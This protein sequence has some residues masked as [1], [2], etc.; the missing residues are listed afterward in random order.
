MRGVQYLTNGFKGRTFGIPDSED[1]DP[2]GVKALE[3][4]GLN[5]R[6]AGTHSRPSAEMFEFRPSPTS[7]IYP[8]FAR[9]S[10]DSPLRG[11]TNSWRD[12]THSLASVDRG[13]QTDEDESKS[14]SNSPTKEGDSR[15]V[16][17]AKE[18]TEHVEEDDVDDHSPNSGP[19][20]DVG[21]S[22]QVG[23]AIPVIARARVVNVPKRVPPRPPALPPRNPDRVAPVAEGADEDGFD[24][25]P[26]DEPERSAGG[27]PVDGVVGNLE[28]K[29]LRPEVNKGNPKDAARIGVDDEFHSIPATPVEK[30]QSEKNDRIPGAFN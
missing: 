22:A 13:T 21:G 15:N 14:A 23:T 12:S 16:S 20:S 3:A 24:Q 27:T 11:R 10:V 25:V 26:L 1:P 9:R 6:E 7:P 8:T 30:L 2:Y 17:P 28:E 4:E 5:I 19:A 29:G 18:E